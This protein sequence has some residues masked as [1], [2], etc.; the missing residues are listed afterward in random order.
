MSIK[1]V[2][3]VKNLHVK[4]F[5]V[6]DATA[7]A[8]K[9]ITEIKVTVSEENT[10]FYADDVPA[11]TA[12]ALSN[13]EIEFSLLGL[14][15]QEKALLLGLKVDETT[16]IL[17]ENVNDISS[18]PEL[19]VT[20]ESPLLKGGQRL[21]C[22]PK[23]T[24][25]TGEDT[26]TTTKDKIEEPSVTIKGVALPTEE[27]AYRIAADVIVEATGTGAMN[28][29]NL[30]VIDNAGKMKFLTEAPKNTTEAKA[31]LVKTTK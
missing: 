18:R 31:A 8:I 24:F 22:I 11:V 16:G 4:P 14:G 28:S 12:N 15:N 17:E 5:G 21:I 26:A 23:V 30:L 29:D 20:F 19:S 3:G 7:T 9:G 2:I 13:I 10:T 25:S 27:G 6:A 1:G